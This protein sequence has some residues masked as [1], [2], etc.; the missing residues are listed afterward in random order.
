V[1][2]LSPAT[3]LYNN[4][5]EPRLPTQ[6]PLTATIAIGRSAAKK[7][8]PSIFGTHQPTRSPLTATIAIDRSAVKEL[9]RST[10]AIRLP[11]TKL[12]EH[13]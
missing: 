13:P 3:P 1:I 4:T 12:R 7:L 9:L 5:N 11:T 2:D 8:L 6:S 10:F